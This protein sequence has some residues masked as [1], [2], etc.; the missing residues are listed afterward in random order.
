MAR[1][2][3]T[4][5]EARDVLRALRVRGHISETD[6]AKLLKSPSVRRLQ[7]KS[8]GVAAAVKTALQKCKPRRR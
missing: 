5:R 7:R 8:T 6:L 4:F 2:A 1:T 3:A